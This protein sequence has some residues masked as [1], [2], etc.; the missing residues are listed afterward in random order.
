[1]R[2][3]MAIRCYFLHALRTELICFIYSEIVMIYE[4]ARL[5]SL[6]GKL[7]FILYQVQGLFY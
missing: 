1:M 5:S 3:K 6:K 7:D 2:V 4:D